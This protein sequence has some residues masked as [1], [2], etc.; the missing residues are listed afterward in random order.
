MEYRITKPVLRDAETIYRIISDAAGEAVLLARSRTYIYEHLRDFWVCRL[1]GTIAGCCALHLVGW[2]DLAE[3]KSFVVARE[4]RRKGLGTALIRQCLDEAEALGVKKVFALTF[5]P[6][7]F[8]KMGF[9]KTD[10]KRLPHKIW[11]ECINCDKFPD[12]KEEAV[13]L[14]IQRKRRSR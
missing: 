5:I 9:K 14:P 11:A 13:V 2:E 6:G 3:I 8:K 1:K 10:K 12:C 4:Y 7:F